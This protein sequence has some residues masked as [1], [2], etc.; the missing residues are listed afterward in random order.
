MT[1]IHHNQIWLTPTQAAEM[2]DCDR[3]SI[4]RWAM[5]GLIRVKENP[6]R[7]GALLYNRKDVEH[8]IIGFN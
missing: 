6:R 7:K 1:R 4:K 8:R 3:S 2:A 5:A